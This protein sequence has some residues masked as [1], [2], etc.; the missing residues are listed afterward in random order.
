M[1]AF[2]TCGSQLHIECSA[3]GDELRLSANK[4]RDRLCV[5]CGTE[6]ARNVREQLLR[7]LKLRE[8]RFVTLT[9]RHNHLSLSEQ[10]DL[11]YQRFSNLRRRN[12]WKQ[13]AKGGAA[14]LEVKVSEHD[15]LW[16]VHLHLLVEGS[17]MPQKELSHEWYAVTGDSHIV[18]VRTDADPA[19]LA[20]Y[21]TKYVTKPAD[22][23]IFAVKDRLDEMIV[24]LKGRRLMLTFGTWRGVRLDPK[25]PPAGEWVSLGTP[26]ALATD[27][28]AGDPR[29]LRFWQAALRRW[30][31]LALFSRPLAQSLPP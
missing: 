28:Q 15:R 7:E 25:E 3:A 31:L 29:A 16:H 9:T 8:W 30:P 11:I 12:W 17:F 10:I 27:A 4:C 26:A 5:P 1:E 2:H 18:D 24:A 13:H 20:A 6:R 14:F 22:S 21:L 19:R 23:S